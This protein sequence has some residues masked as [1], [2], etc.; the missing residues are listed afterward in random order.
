M[1]N[2]LKRQRRK[3]EEPKGMTS[4]QKAQ[5]WRITIQTVPP[6]IWALAALLSVLLGR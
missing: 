5:I 3:A 6:T 1:S 4:R 2:N